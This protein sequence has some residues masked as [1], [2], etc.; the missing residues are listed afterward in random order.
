MNKKLIVTVSLSALVVLAASLVLAGFAFAQTPTPPDGYGP[1]YGNGMMSGGYGRGMMG[2][3]GGARGGSA[4]GMMGN[5][6]G[7]GYG[8]MH[9]SMFNALAEGLG[10]TRAELDKRVAAGE[11][12]AQ[13]AAA[14]GISQ[15]GF[16]TIFT[17]AR[18]SAMSQAVKDGTL[19]QQQADW[20]LSRMA[21]LGAGY[22]HQI[23]STTTTN[24]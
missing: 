21:G 19:T 18:K 22:C 6:D 5:W 15:T 1:G 11:T 13:I 3:L 20:M 23:G 10:V 2:G 4:Y 14:E 7:T 17:D 12:P 8:P 24:P 16:A 9:D